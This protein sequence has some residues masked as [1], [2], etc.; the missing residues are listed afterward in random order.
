VWKFP[1]A[2]EK[3]SSRHLQHRGEAAPKN[4]PP[5]TADESL[6]DEYLAFLRKSFIPGQGKAQRFPDRF[7]IAPMVKACKAGPGDFTVSSALTLFARAFTRRAATSTPAVVRC[8]CEG[9]QKTRR[10]LRKARLGVAF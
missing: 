3:R 4:P 5:V 10:S 9:L 7:S 6:D 1:D 8:T 2:V